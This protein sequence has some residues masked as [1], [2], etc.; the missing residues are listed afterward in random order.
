[1]LLASKPDPQTNIYRKLA[2]WQRIAA[3]SQLYFF[4]KEII[5]GRI[6]R[7]NPNIGEAELEKQVRAL[8]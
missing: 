4:A 2:T 3:A 1:M 6:K 8:F 5:R 7:T